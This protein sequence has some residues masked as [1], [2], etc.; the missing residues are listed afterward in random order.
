MASTA[1]RAQ[2]IYTIRGAATYLGCSEMH[3]Y[4]LIAR[5]LL[6]AVDIS[7][8]D[9]KRPKTRIREDDMAAYIERQTR[10]A[11]TA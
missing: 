3:V 11:A 7:L 9:S 5:G 6:R 4:R 1:T 2:T 10:S 8:P